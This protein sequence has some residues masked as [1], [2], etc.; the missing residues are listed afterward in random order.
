MKIV[1]IRVQNNVTRIGGRLQSA[2]TS[3]WIVT[4]GQEE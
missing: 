1:L 2:P 4:A 3:A